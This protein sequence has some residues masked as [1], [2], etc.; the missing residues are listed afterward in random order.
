[1]ASLLRLKILRELLPLLRN[2]IRTSHGRPPSR[3]EL[4]PPVGMLSQNTGPRRTPGAEVIYV[5]HPVYFRSGSLWNY[6]GD[7]TALV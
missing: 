7:C 5:P 2:K 3:A 1:V 4:T 6:T